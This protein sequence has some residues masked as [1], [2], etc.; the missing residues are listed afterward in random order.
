MKYVIIY[1]VNLIVS[2]FLKLKYIF[3]NI[4]S[5]MLIRFRNNYLITNNYIIVR[6]LFYECLL[7]IID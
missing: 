4:K 2:F 1:L 7:E 5:L 3:K 6:G